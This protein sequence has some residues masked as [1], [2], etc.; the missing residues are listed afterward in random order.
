MSAP[1]SLKQTKKLLS[2]FGDDPSSDQVQN[3]LANGDL[4]KAMLGAD[5]SKVDRDAFKDLLTPPK[6]PVPLT[7]VS[8]YYDR[9]VARA[10]L[11]G[12]KLPQEQLDALK[13]QLE[14]LD[15]ASDFQPVDISMWLG[16]DLAYNRAE[17]VAWLKDEVEAKGLEFVDYTGEGRTSFYPG[18][19]QSGEPSISACGLDI[20][21]FWNPTD[22]VVP[23]DIRESQPSM[24]WPG[25]EVFWFLALNP[26]LYLA[27]DFENIPGLLAPGLV[28][29]S[30]F[31]PY[32]RRNER[33]AWV[34]DSWAVFRWFLLLLRRLQGVVA[35]GLRFLGAWRVLG[36]DPWLSRP[37]GASSKKKASLLH[38]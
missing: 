18:S 30:A 25:L 38:I 14:T 36:F 20:Q 3:L 17:A 15:H 9:I 16:G 21:L 2:L 1:A 37:A 13:V 31:L 35:L 26:D 10:E 7:A 33:E 11:R 29:G 19:E 23:K 8:D 5:L 22:G 27:I 34:S 32:L 6:P 28:V 4:V 24:R 12:W